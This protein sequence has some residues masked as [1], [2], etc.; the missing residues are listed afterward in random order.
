MTVG[1][2]RDWGGWGWAAEREPPRSSQGAALPHTV[3]THSPVARESPECQAPFWLCSPRSLLRKVTEGQRTDL[4]A[5][6]CQA[7]VARAPG[8]P[9]TCW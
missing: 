4:V 6:G 1:R 9:Q 8:P 7:S 2:D 3:V 5:L